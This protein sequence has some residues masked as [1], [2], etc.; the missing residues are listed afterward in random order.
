MKQ[1]FP[2]VSVIIPAR[3]EEDYIEQC[4][5]SVLDS[6]YPKKKLEV[7]V[8][9]GMS[10]D[11][12]SEIIEEYS[13]KHE[14]VQRLENPGLIAS[15]ALNLGIKYSKGNMI[16]RMDA[17]A[18]Y[19]PDY[20]SKCIK[21]L[22]DTGVDNV[23]GMCRMTPGSASIT[24]RGIALALSHPFGVGNSYFRIGSK[25]PRLVDTVPFGCYRREVFEKIGMFN[26]NLARNQ[27]IEF[28][29]RLK[30]A[31]AK[32]LL[33]PDIVSHYYARPDLRGLFKQN[34]WNGFWVIY[35]NR[36][37]KTPFSWR[38][39]I[40]FVFVLSLMGS[41]F[42]SVFWKLFFYLFLVVSG[43][44]LVASIS[45]GL[46]VSLKNSLR[47]YPSVV[48]SFFVLHFSYGLGSLWGLAKLILRGR[49]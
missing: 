49:N 24:S 37:A 4:I 1:E 8:V 48:L 22:Q 14:S 29:L 40:P 18:L 46:N 30:R 16:V 23:G 28:N 43:S 41:L 17:H 44:Y 19:P 15:T 10:E 34:F 47:L 36:Y 35:S 38:H 25:E 21:H 6:G 9:D 27:D 32:I 2:L 5:N 42:L 45:F 39:L 33:V 7:I 20:I 11:R 12:T 3:N 31:G 13:A 26:E